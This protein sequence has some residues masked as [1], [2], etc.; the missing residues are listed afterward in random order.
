MYLGEYISADY[1]IGL[2]GTRVPLYVRQTFGGRTQNTALGAQVRGVDKGAYDAN[3]KA[4][5]N[6]EVRVNLPAIP[7]EDI[8]AILLPRRLASLLPDVIPGLIAYLDA[9]AYDQV[10]EPGIGSPQPGTVAAAGGGA[11]LEVPGLGEL[12]LYAEYR[13]DG[14]NAAGDR[15]RLA[16]EFGMQF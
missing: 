8:A 16:L 12:L 9:G 5:N 7:S 2:N 1:A 6:L 10:G 15:V 13:L 11:F 14:P 3:L 4:V